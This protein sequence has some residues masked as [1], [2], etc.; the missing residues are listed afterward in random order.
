M[1]DYELFLLHFFCMHTESVHFYLHWS[2]QMFPI[3]YR[4][5]LSYLILYFC[6]Y[7]YIA[8]LQFDLWCTLNLKTQPIFGLFLLLV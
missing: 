5:E 6:N 7:V 4:L 8:D 2:V 1:F 3:L